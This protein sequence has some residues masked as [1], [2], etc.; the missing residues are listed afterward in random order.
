MNLISY[1]R[2]IFF[3]GFVTSTSLLAST[4]NITFP[5]GFHKGVA[6]SAYQA[7]GHNLVWHKNSTSFLS[8]WHY[9]ENQSYRFSAKN[10]LPFKR[11][12]IDR[13]QKVGN[14]VDFW[15]QAIEDIKLIKE[16]KCTSYRFSIEWSELE[17]TQGVWNEEAFAFYDKLIEELLKN[18]IEPMVTLYHWVHPFWFHQ[19]GGFEKAENIP[20]FVTY[21][22]KVFERFGSK[23][24][25]WCTINEPTIIAGCGYIMARH[26]PGYSF[27]FGLAGEVLKNL[28]NAHVEVYKALKAMPHGKE[29]QIGIVHQM[30]QFE[31]FDPEHDTC[32]I[33]RFCHSLIG[34]SVAKAMNFIFAHKVFMEFFKTGKFSYTVPFPWSVSVQ[35]FNPDAP[36]SNDFIGLNF[37]SRVAVGMTGPTCQNHEYMTDM[38][39]AGRPET[40]YDAIKEIATLKRPIYITEN[41][42]P[43]GLDKNR[44]HFIINYIKFVKQA[45]EEGFDVRGYYYWTLMDNF[46]WDNGYDQFFGLYHVDRKTQKRTLRPG[47]HYYRDHVL[48]TRS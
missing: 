30:L 40:L 25:L 31:G 14:S 24:K 45:L 23:V 33:V 37:Y 34:G 22:K 2:S 39:Y 35:T 26:A 46:E 15:N 29:V 19:K 6:N 16:L 20:Y 36:S 17:Q 1:F 47:S 3:A 18:N 27:Q 41:G 13:G 42:A 43:D 21:C 44:S 48:L 4:L 8:N 38:P 12:P 9:F 10:P 5:A 7:G 28:F 32:A 11:S